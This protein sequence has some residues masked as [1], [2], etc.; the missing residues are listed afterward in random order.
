MGIGEV[1]YV[2]FN[3]ECTDIDR[4]HFTY[5]CWDGQHW[6][7]KETSYT[8]RD[9]IGKRIWQLSPVFHNMT[10]I[11]TG[12]SRNATGI[13]APAALTTSDQPGSI[14]WLLHCSEF[15]YDEV[16]DL[17]SVDFSVIVPTGAN[18]TS[19]TELNLGVPNPAGQ[20]MHYGAWYNCQ[21]LPSNVCFANIVISEYIPEAVYTWPNGS[22][23]AFGDSQSMSPSCGADP[24]ATTTVYR[25]NRFR[26]ERY[27]YNA[28]RS[29]LVNPGPPPY[30]Q[31]T[32]FNYPQYLRFQNLNGK[33]IT[34]KYHS[35]PGTFRA[36]DGKAHGAWDSQVE[37][38]R[39]PFNY[40]L[41]G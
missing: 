5:D 20:W 28:R 22:T 38:W 23:F 40:P 37:T 8:V 29:D 16:I 11:A 41:G 39:G 24:Y 2:Y 31:S 27:A 10:G 32:T 15:C 9:S 1:A 12:E 4:Y 7:V 30:A 18:A 13:L 14:S 21:V 19:R 33:W 35:L 25:T 26:D 34:F 17:G 36:S 6:V 3:P